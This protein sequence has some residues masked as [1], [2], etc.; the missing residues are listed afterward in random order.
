MNQPLVQRGT[1][2]TARIPIK[3]VA[4]AALPKPPWI[5]VRVSQGEAFREVKQLLREA[6]LH[7]VCEEASCPN[8]GECFGKRRPS[9]C[10]AICARGAARSATCRTAAR[11]RPTRWSRSAACTDRPA[12]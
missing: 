12:P 10:W 3:V 1:A 7:T 11:S 6:S 2:K 4:G 8:I 5:R 9:W